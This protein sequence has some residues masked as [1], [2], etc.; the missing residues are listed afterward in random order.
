MDP[1]HRYYTPVYQRA[2]C[3]DYTSNGNVWDDSEFAM[4]DRAVFVAMALFVLGLVGYIYDQVFK[5]PKS[6]AKK[7][8]QAHAGLGRAALLSHRSA[9]ANSL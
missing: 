7:V 2:S 6:N 5:S 4:R 3:N 8:S 1:P 9:R